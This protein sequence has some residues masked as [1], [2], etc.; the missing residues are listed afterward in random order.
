LTGSVGS[1]KSVAAASFPTPENKVRYVLDFED[2]MAFIDAGEDGKDVYTPRKQRFGM[3]R[4]IYPTLHQI[5]EVQNMLGNSDIGVLILDNIAVFQDNIVQALQAYSNN[6]SS[7][8]DLYKAYGVASSL[9][10]DSQIKRWSN[11]K[12]PGFW[13]A[14]KALPK[15]LIM[16]AMKSGVHIIGTSKDSNIWKNYGSPNAKEIG[17]RAK[18]WDVFFRYFDAVPILQGD[19]NTTNPPWGQLNPLQPKLRLQGFNPRW[20]MDWAGFSEELATSLEREETEIPKELQV[21]VEE[22]FEED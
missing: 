18:I 22:T 11:Q 4:L 7:I 1:G 3:R 5:A 12:D 20:Q 8:L 21:Q 19:I 16:T 9:P 14:A 2:S 17:T 10:F 13:S 6:L 15:A